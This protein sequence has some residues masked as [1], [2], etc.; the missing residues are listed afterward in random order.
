MF[1]NGSARSGIIVLPCGAGKTLTGVTA[2]QTIKKSLCLFSNEC[3]FCSSME[4][5]IS[6]MGKY[7]R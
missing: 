7:T 6:K 3:S 4:I 2:A 1:G 5:P